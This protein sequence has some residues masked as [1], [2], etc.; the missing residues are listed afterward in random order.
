M[1]VIWFFYYKYSFTGLMITVWFTT[2]SYFVE[3]SKPESDPMAPTWIICRVVIGSVS[4]DLYFSLSVGSDGAIRSGADGRARTSDTGIDGPYGE[5]ERRR[6][7]Q[8]QRIMHGLTLKRLRRGD[9]D[10]DALLSLES[11]GNVIIVSRGNGSGVEEQR[12]A[13]RDG[14]VSTAEG[15]STGPRFSASECVQAVVLLRIQRLTMGVIV[16]C[17]AR[18]TNILL[19]SRK[20]VDCETI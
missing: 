3:T 9:Q 17:R 15:I 20:E 19:S 5:R 2:L 1:R 4:S 11:A 18:M 12:E 10:G 6:V 7:Q 16:V 8:W 14:K 13:V